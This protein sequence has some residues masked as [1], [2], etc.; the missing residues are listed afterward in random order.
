MDNDPDVITDL[1]NSL[2]AARITLN[3]CLSLLAKDDQP[4]RNQIVDTLRQQIADTLKE[5]E[6]VR[7]KVLKRITA[8][9]PG[10]STW[11]Q[12]S[13]SIASRLRH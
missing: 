6:V 9:V 11:G 12:S 5:I 7:M 8:D 3:A 13:P 1:M 2:A 4:A 10:V